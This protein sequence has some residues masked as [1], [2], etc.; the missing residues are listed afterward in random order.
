MMIDPSFRRT[1]IARAVA[2][3]FAASLLIGAAHAADVSEDETTA[4]DKV[5]VTSRNREEI[6]QDVPI[7]QSVIGARTLEREGVVALQD[8]AKKAPGLEATTPNSRRSGISIRGIGK[9][10][11]NDALE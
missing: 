1:P 2:G 8:L 3:V 6:A 9:S 5:R 11:G 10:A 4:L 7:P